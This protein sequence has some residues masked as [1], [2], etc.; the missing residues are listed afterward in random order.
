MTKTLNDLVRALD[1]V[2]YNPAS[3][4]TVI[5]DASAQ[6]SGNDLLTAENPF[7]FL[8]EVIA[9]SSTSLAMNL[10]AAT[11]KMYQSLAE[12]ETELNNWVDDTMQL[13]RFSLP[14][15]TTVQFILS[16]DDIER[17]AIENPVT[18]T[19]DIIIPKETIYKVG[20]YY[21]TGHYPII[22]RVL[23]N[24]GLSILYDVSE[25]DPYQPLV[26]NTLK[27]DIMKTRDVNAARYLSIAIPVDQLKRTTYKTVARGGGGFFKRYTF[28]DEFSY[29]RV[30]T[31]DDSNWRE[32]HVTYSKEVYSVF[33]DEAT[34]ILSVNDN[35]VTVEIPLIYYSTGRV[36]SNIKVVIYSTKGEINSNLAQRKTDEWVVDW[37]T[38]DKSVIPY[39]NVLNRITTTQVYSLEYLQGGRSKLDLV[40]QRHR[41]INNPI[42]GSTPV[43]PEQ[44]EIKLNDSGYDMVTYNDYINANKVLAC[45]NLPLVS[46][47]KDTTINV[48]CAVLPFSSTMEQLKNVDTVID[49]GNSVTIRPSTLYKLESGLVKILGN[50]EVTSL[51]GLDGNSLTA[52]LNENQYLYS[53]F[54]W[55]YSAGSNRFDYRGFD[56]DTPKVN[57]HYFVASNTST[58]ET[59][60]TDKLNLIK[61][62]NGYELIVTVSSSEGIE[63]LPE[64]GQLMPQL[65]IAS[66][67]SGELSYLNGQWLGVDTNKNHLFKFNITTS[68]DIKT[69]LTFDGKSYISAIELTG[70]KVNIN[71]LTTKFVDLRSDVYLT[72]T[73]NGVPEI[74]PSECD[75]YTGQFLLPPDSKGLTTERLN[76]TFGE[77]L[78]GLFNASVSIMDTFTPKTYTSDIYLSYEEDI[79]EMTNGV[80]KLIDNPKFNPKKP[81]SES[82]LPKQKVLKHRKGDIAHDS[83]GNKIILHAKG[84]VVLENGSAVIEQEA[85]ILRVCNLTFLDGKLQF[86]TES[87]SRN[88]VKSIP[89]VIRQDLV[90]DIIPLNSKI[91]TPTRLEYYPKRNIGTVDVYVSED[92]IVSINA[93]QHIVAYCYITPN[94]Y[95]DLAKRR[96]LDATIRRI[97][98]DHVRR[99]SVSVDA[100]IEDIKAELDGDIINF[101]MD[102]LANGTLDRYTLQDESYGTAIGTEIGQQEDGTYYL[103]DSIDLYWRVADK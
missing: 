101:N 6:L 63:K 62:E 55:V 93:K 56:L 81:V 41:V 13:G 42:S 102:R 8:G 18:K 14:S 88:Y 64:R 2:K 103:R 79:F 50:A 86:V 99:T 20:D 52:E 27:F 35:E 71:D 75:N 30:F 74:T 66:K 9:S 70:L 61:V 84:S 48:T 59:I 87:N 37:S 96:S 1:N 54:Y 22:I 90:N 26:T 29:A 72:Y 78:D 82:N 76:I 15:K 51:N 36:G 68:H 21:L 80:Y 19:R 45:K 58:T 38:N 17:F 39:S 83:K 24:N 91:L 49:N 43:T 73:V 97:I 94:T 100:I 92:Q 69:E 67:G 40:S 77:L 34:A 5:F 46:L 4:A 65:A 12:T 3:A 85:G 89:A 16:L 47:N 53:P 44:L 11:R 60:N 98:T 95:H 31:G 7:A 32:M 33:G 10:D 25:L 57:A 28:E 23:E